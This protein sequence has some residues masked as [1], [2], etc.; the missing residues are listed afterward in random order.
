MPQAFVEAPKQEVQFSDNEEE[1]EEEEEDEPP[2]PAQPSQQ[3]KPAPKQ[4][5]PK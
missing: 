3:I 5:P 1:Y 2:K 4:E